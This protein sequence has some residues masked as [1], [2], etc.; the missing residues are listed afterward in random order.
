MTG[1][2]KPNWDM[3][4]D[5]DEDCHGNIASSEIK[6]QYPENYNWSCCGRDGRSKGCKRVAHEPRSHKKPRRLR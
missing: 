3:F 5:W 2:M 1:T 4:V 6:A